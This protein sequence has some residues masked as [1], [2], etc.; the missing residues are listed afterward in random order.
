[1]KK[2]VKTSL[3]ASFALATMSTSLMGAQS[4]DEAFANGKLKGAIKSYYF[5]QSF[6]G[7]GKNDSSVWANGG[8]LN[9]ITDDYKGLTFGTTVQTSQVASIDDKD[10]KTTGSMNADGTVL[11]E[12]YLQYTYDNTTLKTGRQYVKTPLLAGSGSR[13]IKESF[14]AHLLVNSDIPNTTVVAGVV[15]KYQTRTDKTSY[16]DNS[17]VDF[18]TDG[19][20]GPGKFNDINKFGGGVQTLYVANNSI[21]NLKAQFQYAIIPNVADAIYADA[22]YDFGTAYVAGQYYG[23]DYDPTISTKDSSMVG[24]KIGTKVAGVDLFA[25]YTSTADDNTVARGIGQGAYAHYTATTKTAGASAFSAGTDSFQIGAGYT[26]DKLKT[27]VR[28]STFD[29]PTTG[30]DLDETTIN[31]T[32]SL[33]KQLQAQVDYSILDYETNSSDATDL[34]SRL[35]YKF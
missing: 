34:R 2:I 12:A 31:L 10:G 19:N 8:F 28:Y 18:A 11:S 27:K 30:A 22:K 33:T 21:K 3:V 35:I 29:K 5:A 16:G 1:M 23:T 17:W 14:E 20:G 6:D 9:F 26:F 4:I 32:Y 13:L 15:T 24:A 7:A 25:G